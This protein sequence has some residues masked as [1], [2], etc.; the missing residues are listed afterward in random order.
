MAE[1]AERNFRDFELG[2]DVYELAGGVIPDIAERLDMK[3]STEPNSQ[4]LFQLVGALGKNRVLRYNEDV[5]AIDRSD[6]AALVDR[7]GIQ[8][9][10]SRSLWTPGI[11][12][13]DENIDAFVITGAV[14]NWQDRAA[15]LLT[16]GSS[17]VIYA[18]AG[19]RVMD[20]VTEK[21]NHNVQRLR[22]KDHRYPTE[23]KYVKRVIAPR[24]EESG[25]AVVASRYLTKEG[26]V[27]ATRFFERYPDL[28]DKRVAFA[29]VANAGIQLAAQM[30]TAAR[31]ISPEFDADPKDPQVFIMT[32]SFPLAYLEAQEADPRRFQKS[33]TA[34][35]QLVL[36][37]KLL[38]EA[39]AS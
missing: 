36:T 17:R 11:R 16:W 6:A 19:N 15:E 5:V 22:A 9:Q 18:A 30:R 31:A 20:T 21:T 7:S 34:L 33:A 35:R 32:D 12:P 37:A 26:P 13:T 27:L 24:L 23:S 2:D 28:L 4:E 3:L 39:T 14:A 25:H 29:R 38:H 10:L 1:M 8:R